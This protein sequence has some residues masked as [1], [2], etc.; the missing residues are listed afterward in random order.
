MLFRSNVLAGIRR[1][2]MNV[3]RFAPG[4]YYYV[5]S[6]DYVNGDKVKFKPAKFMV[7]R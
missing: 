2:E 6:A 7:A 1:I 4:V 5:I 3:E